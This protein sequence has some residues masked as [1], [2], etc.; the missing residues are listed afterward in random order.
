MG[1]M[2]Q[3]Q[4]SYETE[5]PA[6]NWSRSMLLAGSLM[7]VPNRIDDPETTYFD[8]GYNDYKDNAYKLVKNV[9][10]NLPEHVVPFSL[11]DY[12]Q[13]PPFGYNKLFDTLNR[14]SFSAL[15]EMGFSTV[16]LACHGDENGN[17]TNYKGDGGG[18][19]PYFRDYEVHFDYDMAMKIDN[20]NKNPLVYISNC[21]SL[22]FTEDDDTNMERIMSNPNGGAIGIIGATT[23]TYRGEIA[24]RVNYTGSYGN[25]WLAQEYFRILYDETPHPAE[26]LYKQ[27]WNYEN[28]I[29]YDMQPMTPEWFRIFRIDNLAYNLLG[30]PEGAIWLDE[31]RK[32]AVSGVDRIVVTEKSIEPVVT[33]MGTGRPLNGAVVHVAYPD[34][35]V[36]TNVSRTN[37]LG[38]AIMDVELEDLS[39]LSMTVTYPGYLPEVIG[40]EV[41]SEVN[42][43]LKFLRIVPALPIAE[44]NVTFSLS[45]YNNGSQIFGGFQVNISLSAGGSR[46][47]HVWSVSSLG[48]GMN[49]TLEHDLTALPG[50]NRIETWI[51]FSSGKGPIE[52]TLSDNLVSFEF[53]ANAPI[54]ILEEI[55]TVVLEIQE[56]TSLAESNG[57][58]QIWT[59]VDDPDG[60]VSI[61]SLQVEDPSGNVTPY[62]LEDTNGHPVL[63]IVPG[64]NWHGS[65]SLR[66]IARDE[67]TMDERFIAYIVESLPDRPMPIFYPD[68]IASFEDVETN[69]TVAFHDP[70]GDELA[71]TSPES[72]IRIERLAGAP[73]GYFNISFTPLEENVGDSFITLIAQDP[74]GSSFTLQIPLSVEPVNDPPVVRLPAEVVLTIGKRSDL[75]LD[76]KDDGSDFN[77]SA[78]WQYQVI[79]TNETTIELYAPAGSDRGVYLLTINVTDSEGSFSTQK[80]NITL[81]GKDTAIIPITIMAGL[82]VLILSLL[83]GYGVYIRVQERRQSDFLTKVG[84]SK[85]LGTSDL[86]MEDFSSKGGEYLAM[87][88]SELEAGEFEGDKEEME[89]GAVLAIDDL[90]SDIDDVIVEFYRD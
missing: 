10:K 81:V 65:G 15:Y 38:K 45:A 44:K 73:E 36:L 30:D 9:T 59:Y 66:I 70:D 28:H 24:P 54:R 84:N 19:L 7:D 26:A 48:P 67:N 1:I 77:I 16:L 20:R 80:M 42:V 33:D 39:D 25:W 14:S 50:N 60:S 32:M 68:Q 62:L 72:W 71:L 57:P 83:I 61:D 51:Y 89:E 47:D 6:G 18:N 35:T 74:E 5:P 12:P 37:I 46:Q 31:P 86:R 49:I 3:R 43:G 22:N 34:G 2:V 58:F 17:S 52:T 78:T 23:E 87:P 64:P 63:D 8:E 13:D 90:D 85:P 88:P 75:V 11:V 79:S 76:I 4:I 53:E 55:E 56:D 29:W 40:I 69:F 21:G 82:S 41:V 27:K